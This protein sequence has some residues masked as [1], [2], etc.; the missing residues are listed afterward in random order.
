[1]RDLEA[2]VAVRPDAVP[3]RPTRPTT[4]GWPT[5]RGI[6]KALYFCVPRN[7]K[8]LGYWD[9]VADRL[10]KI[11]NCLNLQ[12]IFR[13]LPLFEPP[14]DPALLARAAAAGLDVGAIVNGLNQPL[15]LVRFQLLVQKAAEIVPGGQ[16]ARAATCSRR[17]RRKTARRW[18]ILR[19]RHERIVLE[20]A[21]QVKYGQLQEA[22]KAREGL[23]Q[24]AGDRRAAL[25]LL[26][27]AAGQAARRDLKAIPELGELDEESL[28]KMKFAMTGAGGGA[29]R[30][31]GRHRHRTSAHPAA[32]SIS[33][34]R[35]K[36]WRNSR[37]WRATC[38]TS[39][40]GLESGGAGRWP[41]SRFRHRR[42]TSGASG[43]DATFG[44]TN[45]GVGRA[46]PPTLRWPWRD[47]L[48]YEAGTRRQ[49]RLLRR[50]EQDWAFQSNLAA[51]E[52]T[53]IFK[54]LRAAQIREAIAEQE[55]KNHQQQIKHA[56][57]IEQFPERRGHAD[58][59]QDAPTRRSTPG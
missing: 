37:G 20:L 23:L 53:Q 30:H 43:G 54:Q 19:A 4:S 25:H 32:G 45:L 59:R 3:Q 56:Q 2:D 46:T 39:I 33:S 28:D 15:P 11:R 12:G 13:Q 40:K 58:K 6:G 51:G 55:L 52:I 8:L 7:D 47:G 16:D 9:T 5:V 18:P 24:V 38:R 26:R 50:R 42:C 1:M 41:D 35:R 14:I 34:T 49:D 27:A 57:E 31:R 17:W 10:F 48:S 36:S 29:A 21:E 22:I 44:G